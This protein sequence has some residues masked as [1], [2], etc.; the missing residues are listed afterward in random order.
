MVSKHVPLQSEFGT[1]ENGPSIAFVPDRD[2]WE[3]VYFDAKHMGI[4]WRPVPNTKEHYEM[5]IV[6]SAATEPYQPIFASQPALEEWPTRDIWIQHPKNPNAWQLVGRIDDLITF[7][8]SHKL[9]PT[10]YEMMH[11]DRPYVR[12]AV[13]AAQQH[14]QPVLLLEVDRSKNDGADKETSWLETVWPGVEEVNQQAPTL[15][16]VAKTHILIAP[17]HKPFLQTDKGTVK[18]KATIA[19]FEQEILEIYRRFGDKSP[20]IAS[21]VNN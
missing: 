20:E 3:H 13:L 10:P 16:Q 11:A 6:K 12:S 17:R 19:A 1:T 21:R 14:Y 4:D 8:D 2:D 7:A 9:Y 18:R 15:A 5:V